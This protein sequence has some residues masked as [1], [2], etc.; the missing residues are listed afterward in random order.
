M[1]NEE[2]IRDI[3]NEVTLYTT[4][5]VAELCAVTPETIRNWLN[6]HKL[7]GIR[8]DN[9]WRIKR[10]DLLEFLNERYGT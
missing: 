5:Q 8:L 2:D 9:V 4:Q 7:K 3:D 1:R 10:S 6:E